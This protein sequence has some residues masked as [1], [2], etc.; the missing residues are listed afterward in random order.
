MPGPLERLRSTSLTTWMLLAAAGGGTLGVL[1]PELS[2]DLELISNIFLR[3]I[4]SIIAPV[5]FGVLVR[6]VGGAGGMRVLGRIGLKSIVCFE[7]ATTIALLL[8]WIVVAVWEPGAG[9]TLASNAVDAGAPVSLAGVLENAVPT[10]I[11]DA[12]V[13]GDVV[14]IVVFCLLFG[15]AC[16]SLGEKARPIVEL[17]DALAEVA[18]RYT[19]YVM[20]LAPAAVLAAVASTVARSGSE[21]I[22]GLAKFIA[23]A[24]AAQAAFLVVILGGGML[25]FGVS[26]GR[27]IHFAR[28][29]FVIAFATTSSAAALPQ[30]LENMGRFGVPK[31][32]L[33]M[34]AP[35]SLS[36]NLNGSTIHLAMA[37]LF[38]AQAA[39]IDLSLER[40]VLILLTLKLTSKGVAGIPRANFVIL[41]GL[42]ESFGLP[43]AGLTM[44]L[45]ID[46]LI[47]PVRT[48]VNVLSHCAAPA[49]VAR[50]EGATFPK[51]NAPAQSE[52]RT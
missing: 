51:G 21:T 47:D 16:L 17:A 11:V 1:A 32:V 46:A 45:G 33:G 27:F 52:S 24:W 4:R 26:I 39:G 5:L 37:A 30:T 8:G 29:P 31:R 14:Q 28:E 20:L 12:M 19:H 3:L 7:V 6:A 44:L 35:L 34:V 22:E 43:L 15:L 23:A 50:W 2:Q 25:L 38:V 40:Q 49:W 48:S 18:F 13:R 36:L 9:L 10:S 42:F 41:T